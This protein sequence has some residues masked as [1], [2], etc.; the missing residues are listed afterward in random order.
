MIATIGRQASWAFPVVAAAMLALA[1]A[2]SAADM[3]E[4]FRVSQTCAGCHGTNGAAPGATIPII[5]GQRADYLAAAMRD[6]KSGE[7][8]FYVMNFTAR[9][10]S[11]SQIDEIAAWFAAKPWVATPTAS[12]SAGASTAA[13]RAQ[14]GCND[15]H[16][17]SGAGT[18]KG[19]RIAGQP[20]AY[21]KSAM[22]AYKNGSRTGPE[23]DTMNMMPGLDGAEIDALANF[24]S[25]QR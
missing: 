3:S 7:R 23:A 12:D 16:G 5:G 22:T 13:S 19:P 20:A 21:L 9:A 4:G 10:F 1:G 6:Y 11:D 14:H 8:D 2:A 18:E 17:D 15:C 24:Y 25:G